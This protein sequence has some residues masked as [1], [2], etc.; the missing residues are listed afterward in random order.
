MDGVE[1]GVSRERGW[2]GRRNSAPQT[3]PGSVTWIIERESEMKK[4]RWLIVVAVLVAAAVM[5]A[6]ALA[7]VNV[8]QL[9]TAD[10]T[11][12]S[13]TVSGGNFSG[14][15]NTN[16]IGTL[17]VQG[18]ANYICTNP[19]GHASP[20]QNPVAAGSGTSGPVPIVADKNG[21]ATVPNITASV[22]APP[23]PSA[24]EVGCGGQG[25]SDKWTVT[26]TSL[27]AT[28]AHFEV[29]WSGQLVLCRNYTQDGVGTAC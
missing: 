22:T 2:L 16:A 17:T 3:R 4:S 20:G 18:I 12:A 15:G 7:A 6:T 23:T 9:P 27:Q 1:A 14:L 21:R 25:A 5:T 13:V 11:G 28:S 29:T 10:F 26:L 24:G 8:K 19:Q